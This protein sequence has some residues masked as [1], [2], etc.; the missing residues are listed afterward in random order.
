M[1]SSTLV[2]W[3]IFNL[4]VNSCSPVTGS[5]FPSLFGSLEIQLEV[6]DSIPEEKKNFFKSLD[7][8]RLK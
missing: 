8:G 3:S 7:Q 1:F 5:S 6:L 4:F 2:E